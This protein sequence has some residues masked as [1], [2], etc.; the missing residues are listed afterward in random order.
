MAQESEQFYIEQLK[1]K[2]EEK[3]GFQIREFQDCRTLSGLM[4][5]V[6]INVSAHTLARFFGLLKEAH[7]P[8][9]STLNLLAAFLGKESFASFCSHLQRTH[10]DALANSWGMNS[11]DFS[12][13][14]LEL[15]ILSEDWKSVQFILENFDYNQGDYKNQITVFLGNSVRNHSNKIGFLKALNEIE[16]GRLLFF[17]S[18]VDEDDPDGYYSDALTKFYAGKKNG[19]HKNIFHTCFTNTKKI[20]LNQNI[21]KK[22]IDLAVN[23]TLT[24]H[25]FHFHQ[26]SRMIELH[27]LT[28]FRNDRIIQNMDKH[29]KNVLESIPHYIHYEKCWILA[30][31]LKAFAFSKILDKTFEIP[32]FQEAIFNAYTEMN[33]VVRSIAEL[34]IQ[35]TVHAFPSHFDSM[36]IPPMR[37]TT[38][39]E[40]N[41]RIAIESTTA[42]IYAQAPINKI[43]KK[44][45]YPFAE[46]NGNS[47]VLNIL[48]TSQRK[49]TY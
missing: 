22:D 17:E 30:R 36:L 11:G 1:K 9:T 39:S 12:F 20:Y 31:A 28:D 44:N 18:F 42:L 45:L 46:K 37:F 24:I 3:I 38:F 27:I 2:L 35:L 16:N 25:D 33:G 6:K 15:A 40:N 21:H 10:T 7:R 26:I 49:Y 34:I 43:L 41:A 5:E 29:I 32:E 19:F 8:Y 13:T 47:W 48:N 14:A 4:D 23:Q